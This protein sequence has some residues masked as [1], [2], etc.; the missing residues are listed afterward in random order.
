MNALYLTGE[1]GLAF[2]RG[3][4]GEHPKYLK[5]A[6]CAK[7]FA[8][9]SGPETDRHQFDARVSLHDLHDPYLPAFKML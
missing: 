7:C 5:A 1:I 9:H 8:V 4:Q 3:L 6:A 2:V